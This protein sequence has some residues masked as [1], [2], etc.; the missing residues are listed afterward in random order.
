MGLVAI[1]V[2]MGWF[3]TRDRYAYGTA[4]AGVGNAFRRRTEQRRTSKLG[5]PNK[6]TSTAMWW[7]S[8]GP[9]VVFREWRARR[10]EERALRRRLKQ[11]RAD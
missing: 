11:R 3:V 6:R 9:V 2:V 4:S 1:L 7:K 5:K 10:R 8:I